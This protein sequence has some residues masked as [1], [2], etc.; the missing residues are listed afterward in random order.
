MFRLNDKV[1]LVT[2]ASGA[3]GQAIAHALA[4]AGAK[5][6]LS[7]TNL[8]NLHQVREIIHAS[9][10]IEPLVIPCDLAD[11]LA[12]DR[13]V[14]AVEAQTGAIDILINN[15]GITQD[16]LAMRMSD[17]QWQQVIDVD[18]T[19]CFRL[20]RSA[21][22]SMIRKR[23]GRIINVT[24]VV[25]TMG[26]AGQANYCAAKAGLIGMSKA[27]AREVATRGITINCIAPGFINSSMTKKIPD[28][29]KEKMLQNVPL[30]R[31][32]EPK[33]VGGSIVFLASEEASYIT[34][35]TL[36]INGGLE[37]I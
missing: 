1:A 20:C 11:P 26:N 6:V 37:M 29:L 14:G 27:M 3:I 4:Y 23:F 35:H 18:L 2:G 5:T 24:S 25:A 12:V 33:D 17:D 36:H 32:G 21:I 7:G 30:V 28:T 8:D 34:G 10:L 22:K 13:L 9:G 31:M 15:A 19:S 16:N